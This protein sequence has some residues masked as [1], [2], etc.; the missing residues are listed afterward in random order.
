MR[1]SDVKFADAYIEAVLNGCY[2]EMFDLVLMHSLFPNHSVLDVYYSHKKQS[3]I[4]RCVK[5]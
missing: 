4:C 1:I 2:N 5:L 3:I